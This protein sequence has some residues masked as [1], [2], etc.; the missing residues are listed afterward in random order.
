MFLPCYDQSSQYRCQSLQTKA[1]WISCV[2][3]RLAGVDLCLW[4]RCASPERSKR[5]RPCDQS[6][7]SADVALELFEDRDVIIWKKSMFKGMSRRGVP[8]FSLKIFFN[9]KISKVSPVLLVPFRS[10]GPILTVS[11]GAHSS[12]A[13][14]DRSQPLLRHHQASVRIEYEA[15]PASRTIFAE[16]PVQ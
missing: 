2:P 13:F 12:G 11:E 4:L 14:C 10:H 15:M 5:W 6:R 7:M 16:G 8:L 3:V 1:N 9:R